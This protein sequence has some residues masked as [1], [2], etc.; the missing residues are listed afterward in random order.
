MYT[1]IPAP[2][3]DEYLRGYGFRICAIN[4][5]PLNSLNKLLPNLLEI[6]GLSIEQLIHHHTHLGYLRFASGNFFKNDISMHSDLLT[7]KRIYTSVCPVESYQFCPRCAEEDLDI[8]GVSLWRRAHLLPGVDHCSKHSVSLV[9]AEQMRT[10]S[11]QPAY[12]EVDQAAIPEDKSEDYFSSPFV[13]R[14]SV[15]SNLAMQTRVPLSPRVITWVLVSKSNEVLGN[16]R[17]VLTEFAFENAPFFWLAKHFRLI[18]K[19]ANA[20]T[21]SALDDVLRSSQ[22]ACSVKFYLLAMSLLWE[23]PHEAFNACLQEASAHTGEFHE[24]GAELALNEVLMGESIY[25]SCSRYGVHL[26]E[27]EIEF[28]K[29]LEDIG[30][31]AQSYAKKI[32]ASSNNRR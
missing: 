10:I 7:N 17:S 5:M 23:D 13:H 24:S 21:Y 19:R 4:S 15:L 3:P 29:F 12:A 8:Y 28:R 11:R 9:I 2:L 26:R 6:T 1:N 16:E 14:F 31:M 22:T 25:K 30:P 32:K 18:F 20:A 27:F